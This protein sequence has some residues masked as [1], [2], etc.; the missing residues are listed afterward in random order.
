MQSSFLVR[1][2]FAELWLSHFDDAIDESKDG[3]AAVLEMADN[4]LDINKRVPL[5]IEHS[6]LVV[7]RNRREFVMRVHGGRDSL[8]G[9]QIGHRIRPN[10]C[11]NPEDRIDCRSGLG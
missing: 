1:L 5:T 8:A 9:L 4:L 11:D 7:D 2:F 6:L 10:D 3:F